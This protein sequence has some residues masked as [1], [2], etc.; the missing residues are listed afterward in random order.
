MVGPAN[1]AYE[2][3]ADAMAGRRLLLTFGKLHG[4]VDP[5]PR[6]ERLPGGRHLANCNR[7]IE[8]AEA[9]NEAASAA[10]RL[11]QTLTRDLANALGH[12][13]RLPEN[14]D[15]SPAAADYELLV[16]LIDAAMSGPDG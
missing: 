3:E 4:N 14:L 8:L 7:I 15:P 11:A 10:I 1:D 5:S 2:R 13:F 16:D 12:P 9:G 6:P